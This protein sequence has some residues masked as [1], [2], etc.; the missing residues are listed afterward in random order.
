MKVVDFTIE[1]SMYSCEFGV[2]ADVEIDSLS[3]LGR[4][5]NYYAEFTEEETNA[6]A[7]IV[8]KAI[9]RS[10]AEEGSDLHGE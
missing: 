3:P 10:I 1:R 7:K 5:E 4:T 9:Q 8:A 2:N 6:I